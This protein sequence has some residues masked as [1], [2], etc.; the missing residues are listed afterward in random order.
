MTDFNFE[1]VKRCYSTWGDSYYDDYY[2]P[3]AGYPQVQVDIVRNLL[4]QNGV[5]RVLDAGCGPASMLRQL[6]DLGADLY[7][8]DLTPEMI[9]SG[10]RIFSELKLDPNHLW[11]GNVLD[12][13]AFRWPGDRSLSFDAILCSGVLPHIPAE[14]EPAVIANLYGA[15]KP[16]GIVAVEARNE[17]FALFT[18]NRYSRDFIFNRLIDPDALRA[19]AG[20]E[21]EKL[22]SAL[23]HLEAMYRVDLPPVRKGKADE[24]GYDEVLSRLHNPLELQQQFRK[25]GFKSV[26]LLFYHFHALPP[27]FAAE[28]PEVF[29]S[30]SLAL[31]QDPH[32]WRGMFMASAFVLAAQ[33][34]AEEA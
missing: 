15:V 33:R 20:S 2:G 19:A 22:D 28:I 31:E 30:R 1:S 13:E 11:E 14:I 3:K 25:A 6:T 26:Q 29:R 32:H 9:A 5:R 8:F 4:R 7:G 18:M 21:R 23:S 10:R 16:G 17:L 12:R 27:M 24:P 34:P